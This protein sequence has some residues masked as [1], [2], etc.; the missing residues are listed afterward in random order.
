MRPVRI[1]QVF[2]GVVLFLGFMAM[3]SSDEGDLIIPQGAKI[4]TNLR[5]FITEDDG[6]KKWDPFGLGL[7]SDNAHQENIVFKAE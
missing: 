3:F 5:S 2:V 7:S 1:L 6:E 4:Y